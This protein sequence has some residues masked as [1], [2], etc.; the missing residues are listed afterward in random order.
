MTTFRQPPIL[1]W[2]S[3]PFALVL[4][5]DQALCFQLEEMPTRAG[6]GHAKARADVRG[7]LRSARLQLKQDTILAAAL[8]LTHVA[9][10]ETKC[11]LK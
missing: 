11:Y 3:A 8:V 7:H 1:P 10:L 2:S 5:L 6:R 9:I 4:A